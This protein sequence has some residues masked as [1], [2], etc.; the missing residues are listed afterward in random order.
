MKAW[1]N[2]VLVGQPI[3]TSLVGIGLSLSLVIPLLF[4]VDTMLT[5]SVGYQHIESG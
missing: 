2:F 4:G 3:P 1:L 5:R